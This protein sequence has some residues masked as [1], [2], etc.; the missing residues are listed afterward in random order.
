MAKVELPGFP[1]SG[2]FGNLSLYKRKDSDKWILRRK[3]GI[4]KERL[5]YDP[6]LEGSRQQMTRFGGCSS[7]AKM[8]RDSMLDLTH[9][10]DGKLHGRL[11]STCGSVMDLDLPMPAHGKQSIS[12]SKALYLLQGYTMNLMNPFDSI[13]STPIEFS[14]NRAQHQASLTIP[15]LTPR[16][17]FT[18]PWN[19]P[20]FRFRVNLGIIRDLIFNGAAYLPIN[21]DG[22]EH[23]ESD[24]TEWLP[25]TSQYGGETITLS[26]DEPVFDSSCYLMLAIGVE[27]GTQLKGGL[28]HVR[29]AGSAK[30][31]GVE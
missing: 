9:L 3:G 12:F 14:I 27:F 30:I 21:P 31:L 24:V 1:F 29:G 16:K 18:S 15:P 4:S 10:A 26:F 5:N 28:E 23:T 11:L 17:N 19:F 8:I 13:I 6:T 2:S 22:G 20:F 25:V 7:A